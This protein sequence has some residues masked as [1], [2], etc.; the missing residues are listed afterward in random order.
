[1]GYAKL[2]FLPDVILYWEGGVFGSIAYHDLRI[3]HSFTR[4]IEDGSVP[5][6]ATIVDRTTRQKSACRT[7]AR[8]MGPAPRSA[9]RVGQRSVSAHV[10]RSYSNHQFSV[11]LVIVEGYKREV[12]TAAG[13]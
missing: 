2:F 8:L 6:D 3:D 7:S 12:R 13:L 9:Q 11:R 5:A 1:M 10:R 4:F